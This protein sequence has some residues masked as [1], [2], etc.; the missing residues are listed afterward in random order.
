VNDVSTQ[1]T[2]TT[3]SDSTIIDSSRPAWMDLLENTCKK[4]KEV[5][6]KSLTAAKITSK[7]PVQRSLAREISIGSG[8]LSKIRKDLD[9]LIQ[10]C[11]GEVKQTNY[12]R[13]LINDVNKGIIPK[14]WKRYNVMSS[15][16]LNSW[17]SDFVLR[18]KQLL[19]IKIRLED[20]SIDQ[21]L[22]LWLGGLFNPEAFITATRQAAARA[23]KWSLEDL[24]LIISTGEGDGKLNNFSVDK[25][26]VHSADLKAPNC[27]VETEEMQIQ[28][29]SI[30]FKWIKKES[31]V[32][33][34]NMISIPV[35]LNNARDIVLFAVDVKI[36]S[37]TRPFQW[38]QK[39]LAL[40]TNKV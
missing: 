18:I 6:P 40:V 7:G 21:E 15:V 5:L 1:N 32:K 36:P 11:N 22:K 9:S 2:K 33:E 10:V 16:N 39:G 3:T 31:R 17:I 26:A 27:I 4:W 29:S 8:L 13:S 38:Y 19:D 30:E 20:N 34:D 14:S 23:N 35:Y 37:N 25:I 24:V 28:L 12:L